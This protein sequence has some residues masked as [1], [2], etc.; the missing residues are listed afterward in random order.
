MLDLKLIRE[1][2]DSVRAALARRGGSYPID[3]VLEAD[4]RRRTA[5]SR[6]DELRAE[7]KKGD[8]QIAKLQ[9][10]EKAKELERLKGLSDEI[11]SLEAEEATAAAELRSEEHTS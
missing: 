2:A 11:A 1:D 4:A 5:Q 9:G 8:K 7:R 6:I 3:E 10:D